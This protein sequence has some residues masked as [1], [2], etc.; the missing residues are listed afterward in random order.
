MLHRI[1]DSLIDY[2]KTQVERILGGKPLRPLI[3][4]LV[5]FFSLVLGVANAVRG[6][7]RELL[8]PAIWIGLPMGLILA[9]PRIPGWLAA[10]L[11][12][13]MGIA[14]TT[15]QITHQTATLGRI[16]RESLR[17]SWQFLRRDLVVDPASLQAVLEEFVA[18][19][20]DLISRLSIWLQA[21]LSGQSL[22]AYDPLVVALIWGLILWIL[23][24][25]AGWAIR[26][27]EQPLVSVL[28]AVTALAII[29]AFVFGRIIYLLPMVVAML[30]LKAHFESERRQ[31]HW[32]QIGM[33]FASNIP[34][35]IYKT[36]FA[37]SSTLVIIAA[38]IPSIYSSRVVQMVWN[39]SQGGEIVDEIT[40]A[41][42]LEPRPIS[43]QDDPFK[44]AASGVLPRD[45]LINAPPE[46]GEQLVMTVKI[47]EFQPFTIDAEIKFEESTYYWRGM[48]FDRYTGRGWSTGDQRRVAYDAGEKVISASTEQQRLLRQEVHFVEGSGLL[49]AA[50]DLLSVDRD[51]EVAWQISA[52]ESEDAIE[53]DD[54]IGASLTG[55]D[56]KTYLADSIL[57]VYGEEDLR[58]AGRV[59]PR[60]LTERYL[61]LPESVPQRVISLAA[62]LTSAETNSYD[63]AIA[64][65]RY[66]RS[67]PYTLDVPSPPTNQ[68][69]ADYF[70]FDLQKGYCDYYATS[71]VVMARAVG[72]PARLATG[73]IGGSF[74]QASGKYLVTEDLAHSWV[75]IYFDGYGW[76][77]FEPTA[78][79]QPIIRPA[80]SLSALE[81]EIIQELEPILAQRSRANWRLGSGI[82]LGMLLLFVGSFGIW[83]WVDSWN[84]RRS[85]PSETIK[86][87]F[88]RLYL[89]APRLG[90]P[91]QRGHTPNEFSTSLSDELSTLTAASEEIHTLTGLHN[92]ASYSQD[93]LS[94]TDQKNAIRLWL[95]LRRRLLFAWLQSVISKIRY[96]KKV[97]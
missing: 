15:L 44:T 90:L 87:L 85:T 2:C 57:R 62:D 50:G 74:D 30:M 71:M 14:V 79:R 35:E 67:F 70:L 81:P 75:Q 37:V 34:N 46:L 63:Q 96:N 33:P 92:R 83:V 6:L 27:R 25:W 21:N 73:Y 65:E 48:I 26:R 17:L 32:G 89:Y 28:P 61:A 1:R 52:Q 22:Y 94:I 91:V 84:L 47:Q 39:I 97:I 78:G 54:P 19:Q 56:P 49:Y 29:L 38:L 77:D 66:L 55:I 41:L 68:D 16:M 8:W 95:Q 20:H 59:Y 88:R 76:V 82:G 13:F 24:I 9:H 5:I 86:N 10:I 3:L 42:G 60:W 23:S 12:A 69:I 43:A 53:F 4:F 36:A 72:L 7:E 93:M 45:H 58:A 18:A 51:F 64:I 80:G 31:A 40:H 11:G